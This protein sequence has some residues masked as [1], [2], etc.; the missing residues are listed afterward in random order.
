MGDNYDISRSLTFLLPFPMIFANLGETKLTPL[1]SKRMYH[2]T[3]IAD[4]TVNTSGH[5]F[6]R[7]AIGAT[8]SEKDVN[9]E[10]MAGH[11]PTNP[12]F[13]IDQ[14]GCLAVIS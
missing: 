2:G 1:A 11:K 5:L 12:S 3:N 6:G 10:H 14:P 8:E 4:N 7:F 9:H 13:Q